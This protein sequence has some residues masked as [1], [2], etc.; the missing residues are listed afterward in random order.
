MQK[1]FKILRGPIFRFIQFL[2][3][4]KSITRY[5]RKQL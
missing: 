1:M 5:K 3:L 2:K 4:S